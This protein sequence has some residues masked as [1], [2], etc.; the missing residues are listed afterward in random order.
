MYL[1]WTWLCHRKEGLGSVIEKDEILCIC[2]GLGSVIEKKQWVGRSM[3]A[4]GLSCGSSLLIISILSV[5][6]EVSHY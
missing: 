5:K 1:W 2:G 4:A 3:M 6:E